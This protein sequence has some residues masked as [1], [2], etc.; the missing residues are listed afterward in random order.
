MTAHLEALP[1]R[2]RRGAAALAARAE[3]VRID[4]GALDRLATTIDPSPPEPYDEERWTGPPE[5]RAT[6]VVAWNAANFGSG[7]F[8]HVHKLPGR[9]G[10]RTLATRWHQHCGLHGVPDS[11]WLADVSLAQVAEV[12]AQP[13]DGEVVGLLEAFAVAW[14]ELGEHLLTRHDGSAAAMVR[15]ADGSG[16]ALA[17]ELAGLACWDDRH[18]VDGLEVP[19]HKRAQIVVSHLSS[20]LQGHELGTFAD[21]HQLTAF[22][23]NLVPH[24][25]KVA[26]VLVVDAALDARIEREE[27]LVSGER[28]E[29]ELRALGLHAVELLVDRLHAAGH[30][31]SRRRRSTTGSGSRGRTR[32]SRPGPDTAAGART[33]DLLRR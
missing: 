21:V 14:R 4:E 24:V 22:A 32:P 29:V 25:L 17:E 1:D 2:V 5:E 19:L 10:A 27:L 30:D 7:W 11:R 12:F 16:A 9:S 20:A 13:T 8:P 31:R 3:L 18:L 6:A 23:D 26:G 15:A 33:T 28:G